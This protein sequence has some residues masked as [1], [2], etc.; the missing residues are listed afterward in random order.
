MKLK[1]TTGDTA[2]YYDTGSC[3]RPQSGYILN[4]PRPLNFPNEIA[5]CD[6]FANTCRKDTIVQVSGWMHDDTDSAI[7]VCLNSVVARLLIQQQP[8][9]AVLA[10]TLPLFEQ[11]ALQSFVMAH[12][13]QCIKSG[14]VSIQPLALLNSISF[15]STSGLERLVKNNQRT[16]RKNS[17]IRII[18]SS[19][20]EDF[21]NMQEQF[22][23]A[24]FGIPI[25]ADEA[26][27]QR[28]IYGMD[29]FFVNNYVCDNTVIARN[30]CYFDDT[31]KEFYDLSLPWLAEYK[32]H[33]IGYYSIIQN[34]MYAQ[35]H[36]A[37]YCLGGG[38]YEYKR[39]IIQ[40]F[41]E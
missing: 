17:D 2:F 30:L 34:L 25:S 24:R 21:F 26:C 40:Y 38:N 32:K 3:P 31:Q 6:F 15:V 12:L 27:I 16:M 39:E 36:Q 14:M 19:V 8:M 33:R 28:L 23:M 4:G 37:S 35:K 10:Q 41:L 20:D 7:L 22:S 13:S 5:L 29:R 11:G 1:L 18:R 9:R